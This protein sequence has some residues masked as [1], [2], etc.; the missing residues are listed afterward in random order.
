MTH[1]PFAK[2][3]QLALVISFFFS[4]PLGR[5]Q[6]SSTAAA[7]GG[8]PEYR[9]VQQDK[10]LFRIEQ[11]PV[12]GDGNLTF[13]VTS[14]GDLYLPITQAAPGQTLVFKAV[15]KT[16]DELRR[17]IKTR[18]DEEFYVDATVHLRLV[19]QSRRFGQV[20][21]SGA[22]RGAVPLPPGEPVTVSQAINKLGYDDFA[23]LSK[24]K[25]MRTDPVS[26]KVQEIIVNVEAVLKKGDHS[27]DLVLQDNDVVNVPDQ[28]SIFGF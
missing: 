28:T 19:D 16:V 7:A 12:K 21:F 3:C 8:A 9:L 2:K 15:G 11:D 1:H 24:V 23:K 22:V 17:E 20:I 10:L 6:Q 5:A 25:V 26:K 13:S 27:Q 14:Q 18:L 4:S